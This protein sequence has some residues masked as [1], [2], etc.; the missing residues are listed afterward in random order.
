VS[1][2]TKQVLDSAI[3]AHVADEGEG[4]LTLGYALIVANATE[5][6][7]LGQT[8][9]LVVYS[10]HQPFHVTLGLVHRHRLIIEREEDD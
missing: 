3:A 4:A 9:Y 7:E 5:D 2:E 8:G 10:D 6:F 1:A